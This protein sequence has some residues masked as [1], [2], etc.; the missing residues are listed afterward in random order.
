VGTSPGEAP[1]GAGK[2]ATTTSP[3]TAVGAGPDNARAETPK[4]AG[5]TPAEGGE[6]GESAGRE[7]RS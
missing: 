4:S 7:P 5:A 2:T 3:A 1:E 6:T